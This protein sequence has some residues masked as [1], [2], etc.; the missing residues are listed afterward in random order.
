MDL[1]FLKVEDVR[2]IHQH[3][4]KCYGGTSGL[5]DRTL[6]HSA[7]AVAQ[8]TFDRQYL[9][10]DI[11]EMAAA[12]LFHLVQNHPF[13]DGNKRTGSVSAIVFLN[14][15]GFRLDVPEAEFEKLVRRT[16]QGKADKSEI[17]N[18]FREYSFRSQ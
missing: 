5:R 15:N 3:Q 4:I 8:A 2:K 9:H 18:F 11:F 6:L 14:Y 16:A 12:Y 13:I 7:V 10:R 1:V 17:A